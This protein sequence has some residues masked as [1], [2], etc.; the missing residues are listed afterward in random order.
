V[1][2]DADDQEIFCMALESIDATIRCTTANDG[3]HALQ[4]LQSDKFFK[5]DFIFIDINMPRMNGIECLKQIKELGVSNGA[6]MIMYST[7]SDPRII[8]LS[9][10]LGA[11]DFM[12]KPASLTHLQEKLIKKLGYTK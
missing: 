5:P 6:E 1:D 9:K 10:K 7:T 8:E 4:V 2:D 3:I 12:I 11:S